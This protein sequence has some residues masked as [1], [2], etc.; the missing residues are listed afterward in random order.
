MASTA[1][2]GRARTMAW[3]GRRGG[4]TSRRQ[5]DSPRPPRLPAIGMVPAT[6]PRGGP[7]RGLAAL[8]VSS[9]PQGALSGHAATPRQPRP[10]V[11]PGGAFRPP[12][13]GEIS[14]GDL[15]AGDRDP[16]VLV[17]LIGARY[18]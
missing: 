7:L 2:C 5:R 9:M 8:G 3:H 4:G 1:G 6:I 17:Q 18:G 14:V 11:S 12:R 13:H 15:D 16:Q 10:V